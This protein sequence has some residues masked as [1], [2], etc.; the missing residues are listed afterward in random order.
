MDTLGGKGLLSLFAWA[1]YLIN[2][3]FFNDN[4]NIP[5]F[6]EGV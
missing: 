4:E 5:V 6:L 1:S 3:L 2:K